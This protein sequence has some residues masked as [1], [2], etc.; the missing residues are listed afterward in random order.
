MK[1]VRA[2]A[3]SGDFVS[4]QTGKTYDVVG[5]F[6][7]KYYDFDKFSS[8]IAA[9]LTNK[10]SIDYTVVDLTTLSKAHAEQI[11]QFVRTLEESNLL[12][13]LIILQ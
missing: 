1:V 11:V 6:N 10:I 12:S 4:T 9:H 13:Q 7:S 2:P 5:G 8:S 3:G